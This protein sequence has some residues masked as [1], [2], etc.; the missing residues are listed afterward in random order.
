MHREADRRGEGRPGR[1]LRQSL[2]PERLADPAVPEGEHETML[3]RYSD[4]Q[5]RF[6]LHDGYAIDLKIETV[7]GVGSLLAIDVFFSLAPCPCPIF[8]FP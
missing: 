8:C 4:L 1:R 3:H 5:D 2:H 6:R 7:F